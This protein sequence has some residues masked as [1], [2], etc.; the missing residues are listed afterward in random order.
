MFNIFDLVKKFFKQ[1]TRNQWIVLCA[2]F[3]L[4][5]LTRLTKLDGFPIFSDEGIYIRW[6]KVAW[7]DATWRFISLTDGRQPLQTWATIPFLKIFESN[8]LLGG[9]LFAV[10][11]GFISLTGVVTIGRYLFGA[12]TALIAGF[13]YV[14]TPY[15]L[16]YDRIALVDSAVNA[17]TLWIFFLS[18]VL[19]RTRRLD[20]ALILGM[21]SG[22]ALLAKSSIRLYVG[23]G[24]LAVIFI[25]FPNPI[26]TVSAYLQSLKKLFSR[27]DDNIRK[28][29]EA[30]S[31][32]F[33]YI[34]VVVLAVVTY[35]VQRLS[36]FLHYVEEK[37]KTF[38]LTKQEL[39]SDPFNYFSNNI[40]K[41]PYYIFAETGYIVAA[42]GIVGL[43][44]M[45]R[46]HKTEA[47]YFTIWLGTA[48]LSISLVARVLFP[49]Y[50]LS[51]GGLLIIPAAYVIAHMRTKTHRYVTIALVLLSVAYFN[52][53]IMFDYAKIPFPQVDRGQYLE[54]WPAGWGAKEIMIYSREV[55]M[56]TPVVIIAEGNFG[57]SHDVLDTF[58]QPGDNISI[59]PYWPLNLEQLLQHQ[60]DIPDKEV[61]VVF[62]HR[63]EFPTDWPLELIQKYDKPGDESELYF[64]RL[65]PATQ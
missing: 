53:T 9:R 37:N 32:Y 60:K 57:M 13:L 58:M 16:F 40:V 41:L 6:A 12:P 43:I 63:R 5:F 65:L 49:R 46:R 27:S 44:F 8:A 48:M 14:I 55:S 22:L 24:A 7:H 45:Y 15:F 52:Y 39:L 1:F 23:L 62:A 64:F 38:I 30:C 25:L 42:L 20:V 36:P 61:F 21:V 47:L 31:F 3:G 4:F 10:T 2:V 28:F 50:V 51:L 34:I 17:S 35:N 18:I 26:N 29:Q 56:T 11:A 33:L 59:L 19:A 54:G